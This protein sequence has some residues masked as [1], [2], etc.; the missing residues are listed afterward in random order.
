MLSAEVWGP[1]GQE[2]QD[3]AW[4]WTE[5]AAMNTA[6]YG[7]WGCV[8]S[9]GQ[10]AVLSGMGYASSGP[11]SSCE[12]LTLGENTHWE[13]LPPMHDTRTEFAYAA[14]AGCIIVAGGQNHQ[15]AEVLD[16]MMAAVAAAS[17]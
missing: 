3:V 10:Y 16:E 15:S 13:S 9:G 5:L 4:T 14:V 11:M 7:W 6:Q 12:A 17:V 1:P 8:M 2:A